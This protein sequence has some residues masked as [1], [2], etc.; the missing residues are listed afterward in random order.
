MRIDAVDTDPEDPDALRLELLVVF[1][2]LGKLVP[3]T[4]REV[5][6]VEGDHGGP[7]PPDGLGQ[8]DR[9]ASRRGE[10]EVRRDVSYFEHR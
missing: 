5:E 6:D 2:E 7:V 9:R 1:P 3:S 8:L 10:L 4:R